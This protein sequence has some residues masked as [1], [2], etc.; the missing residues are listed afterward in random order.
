MG[1]ESRLT[2]ANMAMELGAKFG[3]FETDQK[4]VDYLRL[5]TDAPFEPVVADEDASYERVYPISVADLEPQVAL[6]YSVDN[7]ASVSQLEEIPIHQAVLGSCT[8]GRMEDLQI[9]AK[10][11]KGR[12]IQPGLRML[13]VPASR[14]VYLAAMRQGLLSIF[15]E[16]GAIICNPGCGPCFGAHMGLL[17]AQENCVASINRNFKG[18]MGS[19][20]ARVFLASPATVAASALEGRIVDPRKFV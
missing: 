17:A 3:L 2:M 4:T 18:R 11:I 13:V 15:A 8:N 6:P 14:K 20:Q 9:A 12:S 16:A 10:I 1:V 19:D 5:V 7:V